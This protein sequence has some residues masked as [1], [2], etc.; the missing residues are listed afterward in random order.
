M[1]RT[2]IKNWY[3]I[4][5]RVEYYQLVGILLPLGLA[6]VTSSPLHRPRSAR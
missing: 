1:Q 3:N 4:K 2:V 5:R 6:S